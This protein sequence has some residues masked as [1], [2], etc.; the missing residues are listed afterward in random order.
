[1]TAATT[2][3]PPPGTDPHHHGPATTM[4]PPHDG[5]ALPLPSISPVPSFGFT[6]SLRA[7][8]VTVAFGQDDGIAILKVRRC[9]CW[10]ALSC[11]HGVAY[12]QSQTMLHPQHDLFLLAASMYSCV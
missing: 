5:L 11:V 1:M 9:A 10:R 6:F 7:Y 4:L 3:D 12:H 2:T 8:P